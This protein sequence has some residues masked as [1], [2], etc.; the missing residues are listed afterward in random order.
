MVPLIIRR[1][2]RCARGKVFTTRTLPTGAYIDVKRIKD[3]PHRNTLE[4]AQSS[5]ESAKFG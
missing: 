3:L 4:T 2:Q 1:N 5:V